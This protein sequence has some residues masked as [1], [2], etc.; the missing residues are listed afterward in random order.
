MGR[1]PKEDKQTR[2]SFFLPEELKHG[3]ER[4]KEDIGVPETES[5]RRAL[6]E[7]LTAKG[8]DLQ[9][10]KADAAAKRKREKR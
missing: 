10:L 8:Y 7:Y 9:Q 4:L 2:T 6:R 5:V 1:K 3:L